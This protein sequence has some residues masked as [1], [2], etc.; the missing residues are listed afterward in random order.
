MDHAE[1]LKRLGEKVL[2]NFILQDLVKK[3]SAYYIYGLAIYFF[4]CQH[5]KLLLR[6]FEPM[7]HTKPLFIF[8][9]D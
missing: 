9:V 1:Q 2:K 4:A 3:V 7:T 6:Y 5:F 8:Q